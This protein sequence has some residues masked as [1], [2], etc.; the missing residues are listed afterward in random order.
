[1]TEIDIIIN[2]K[3]VHCVWYDKNYGLGDFYIIFDAIV[4]ISVAVS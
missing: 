2:F 3:R 1:M 4:N